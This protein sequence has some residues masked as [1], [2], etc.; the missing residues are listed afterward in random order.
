M[1]DNSNNQILYEKNNLQKAKD[2]KDELNNLNKSLNR[3]MTIVVQSI[4]SPDVYN[5]L[6]FM[7]N[8]NDIVFK[9]VMNDVDNA[10]NDSENKIQML[11]NEQE[12][13]SKNKD[14]RNE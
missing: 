4:K 7:K 10:I 8:D 2:I 6:S 1:N 12:E 3:C 9:N 11:K 13:S 14:W 5:K